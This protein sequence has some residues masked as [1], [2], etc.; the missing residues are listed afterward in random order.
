VPA[1]E[2]AVAP[3]PREKKKKEPRAEGAEVPAAEADPAATAEPQS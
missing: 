1:A 2:A 3:P